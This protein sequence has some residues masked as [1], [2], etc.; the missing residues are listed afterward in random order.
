[1]WFWEE[2]AAPVPPSDPDAARRWGCA[3][4][5]WAV[6]LHVHVIARTEDDAAPAPGRP[7]LA[8]GGP[9]DALTLLGREVPTVLGLGA[10]HVQVPSRGAGPPVEADA[11]AAVHTG[12]EAHDDVRN[13]RFGL[14]GHAHLAS[15]GIPTV[16]SGPR[17]GR[18]RRA[19]ALAR[20]GCVSR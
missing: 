16:G 15:P 8:P 1:M 20:S 19:R 2:R 4:R 5:L 12:H 14:F 10:G 3:R 13:G 11:A 18:G 9:E 6:L 17:L 7:R